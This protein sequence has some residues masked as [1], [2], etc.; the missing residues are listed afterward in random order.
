MEIISEAHVFAEKTGLGTETMEALIQ[1]NYGPL[2]HM[3]S[4]RLTTG[5]YEPARGR[6]TLNQSLNL[7]NDS[8]WEAMVRSKF[9]NQGCWPRNCVCQEGRNQTEGCGSGS[10]SLAAGKE[11]CRFGW[12]KTIGLLVDV[13]DYSSRCWT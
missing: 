2:A 7:T 4:K 11:T 8:R 3:M 10:G 5:A 13:W 1:E 9:G 6:A 12:W